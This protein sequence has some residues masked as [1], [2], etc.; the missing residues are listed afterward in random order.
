[1]K[2]MF[3]ESKLKLF[4]LF[5]IPL[6]TTTMSNHFFPAG[7]GVNWKTNIFQSNHL[8][9]QPSLKK[10]FAMRSINCKKNCQLLYT[11]F[12]FSRWHKYYE[13]YSVNKDLCKVA[14]Q[15]LNSPRLFV[16]EQKPTIREKSET[17]TTSEAAEIYLTEFYWIEKKQEWFILNLVTPCLQ[18]WIKNYFRIDK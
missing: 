12:T 2:K 17:T 14:F 13:K 10:T 11:S 4:S 3:T 16:I 8:N 9:H 1:M 6:T 18:I 15:F 7:Q 5:L